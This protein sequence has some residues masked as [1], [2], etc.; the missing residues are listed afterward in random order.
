MKQQQQHEC[1]DLGATIVSE[2]DY[3][4]LAHLIIPECDPWNISSNNNNNDHLQPPSFVLDSPEFLELGN[5]FSDNLLKLPEMSLQTNITYEEQLLLD[6]PGQEQHPKDVRVRGL[7]QDQHLHSE[8]E[9]M[10]HR[11]SKKERV[12]QLKRSRSSEIHNITERR[13]RDKI[14]GKIKVLQ[15]LMP[16]C[17]KKDRASILEDAV[18]YMK[19]LKLQ[20]ETLIKAREGECLAGYMQCGGTPNMV[21]QSIPIRSSLA[22]GS[23]LCT[24]CSS[25][26]T[27]WVHIPTGVHPLITPTVYPS[28]PF[29]L[30]CPSPSQS[31]S[32]NLNPRPTT[33]QPIEPCLERA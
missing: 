13:R 7:E 28:Y 19:V 18:N 5:N 8:E 25:P 29:S 3:A 9:M 1:M 32:S 4:S 26:C 12:D 27:P 22:Y 16:H 6:L 23:G 21:P 14:T 11:C 15:Q 24:T 2:Q 33:A 10:V 20:I 17:N 30:I 31:Q